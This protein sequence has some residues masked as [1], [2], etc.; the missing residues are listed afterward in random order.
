MRQVLKKKKILT[1]LMIEA[2]CL[3][4]FRF[5]QIYF[6]NVFS[7]VI[8]FPLEQIAWVLRRMSLAGAFGNAAAIVIF[9]IVGLSPCVVYVFLRKKGAACGADLFLFALSVLL[10]GILYYLINP[11]LLAATVIGGKQEFLGGT[12]YAV[13]AGYLV[14]RMLG[15][16]RM[17][18]EKKLKRW[19]RI[20]ACIVAIVLVYVVFGVYFGDMLDSIRTVAQSNT[21]LLEEAGSFSLHS[22]LT[23]TYLFF[24][25]QFLTEAVPYVMDIVIVLMAIGALD[26]LLEDAYSE[27]AV[28]TVESLGDMCIKALEITAALHVIFHILQF[29]FH[30]KLVQID[31]SVVIPVFSLAF[32]LAVL[33][34]V[35]Y[36]RE[37][38]RLKSENDLF[39]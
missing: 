21:M 13:L 7:A 38:Q 5:L 17:A 16:F 3:V 28:H 20:L 12:F 10:F 32:V 33:L 26:I 35:R 8:A 11:G 36:V 37:N 27:E 24:V 6:S 39:V 29:L 31:V 4:A 25:L 19:L 9:L 18:D 2:V 1:A 14:F 23:P 34:M 22:P 30:G 15:S